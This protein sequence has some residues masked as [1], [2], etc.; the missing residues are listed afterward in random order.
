M[1]GPGLMGRFVFVY[2][3]NGLFIHVFSIKHSSTTSTG[4]VRLSQ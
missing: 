1:G 3:A 2:T 4:L